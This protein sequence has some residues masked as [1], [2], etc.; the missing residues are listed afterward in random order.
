MRL[1]ITN[2][3]GIDAPGIITLAQTLATEHEVWVVAPDKNR[4]A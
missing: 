4:S 3:D 1:L 2:D